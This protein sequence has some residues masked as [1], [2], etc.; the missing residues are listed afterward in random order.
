MSAPAV[1]PQVDATRR[2]HKIKVKAEIFEIDVRYTDLVYIASG[3][4]GNV[5]SAVDNVR[6]LV[7]CPAAR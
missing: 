3:A 6:L 7:L 1:E 2:F 5:C 4:Y